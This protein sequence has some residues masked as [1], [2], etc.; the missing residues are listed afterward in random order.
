[1]GSQRDP[2]V[3]GYHAPRASRNRFR[4]GLARSLAVAAVLTVACWRS[5][6]PPLRVAVG[7]HLATRARRTPR[8]FIFRAIFS[9]YAGR[10]NGGACARLPGFRLIAVATPIRFYGECAVTR[11]PAADRPH[12]EEA[13]FPASHDLSV[14][15]LRSGLD[16]RSADLS[17]PATFANGRSSAITAVGWNPTRGRPQ[18]SSRAVDRPPADG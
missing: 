13:G 2:L 12:C 4:F 14:L 8:D 15:A 10:T 16:L 9:Y 5:P 7:Q 11:I 18:G 6:G 17:L 1:M 3:F